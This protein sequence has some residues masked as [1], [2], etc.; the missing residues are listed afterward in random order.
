M[1]D[2][3]CKANIMRVKVIINPRS[4]KGRAREQTGM[5]EALGHRYGDLDIVPTQRSGHATELAA[6]AAASSVA[7][8]DRCVGT[9]SKS[10]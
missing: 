10:P 4:G 9:I 3:G 8:P 1:F 2:K 6:A 7:W 5:I